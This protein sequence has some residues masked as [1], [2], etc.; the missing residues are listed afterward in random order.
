MHYSIVKTPQ[1]PNWQQICSEI[2]ASQ[3]DVIVGTG[4]DEELIAAAQKLSAIAHQNPCIGIL[5]AASLKQFPNIV[6]YKYP[7]EKPRMYCLGRNIISTLGLTAERIN[8]GYGNA[9]YATNDPAT[10]VAHSYWGSLFLI[11][12]EV[13]SKISGPDA[14]YQV[15]GSTVPTNMIWDDLALQVRLAGYEVHTTACVTVEIPDQSVRYFAPPNPGYARWQFKWGWDPLFPNAYHIRQKWNGTVIGQPLI[16]DL[17]EAWPSEHPP[18]D[19]IMLTADNL[20]KLKLCME[21]LAKTN[22]PNSVKFHI[23]VNGIVPSTLQYLDEIKAAYPFPIEVISCPINLG[24]PMAL[25]WLHTRCTAP[26]LARV[27]DDI[28]VPENWLAELVNVLHQYPFAAAINPS[29]QVPSLNPAEPFQMSEPPRVYDGFPSMPDTM[30][31]APHKQTYLTNFLQGTCAVFRKKAIDMSKGYDFQ[32]TPAQVEDAEYGVSL[33]ALGF[34]LLVYGKV[35]VTHHVK[36]CPLTPYDIT[37][38]SGYKTTYYQ[39]KWGRALEILEYGLDRDGR[40]I[41]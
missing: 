18:V 7:V 11:K 6:A 23:L 10:T 5:A 26:I 38:G 30:P 16:Q 28:E 36:Q 24:V 13:I 41:A 35:T 37:L 2:K 17:F 19:L 9:F 4:T 39:H 22:Y 25:N 29:F 33:R 1:N 40:L 20:T 27:D 31:P 21:S 8:I 34:D 32:L 3:T 15:N 12:H 14:A